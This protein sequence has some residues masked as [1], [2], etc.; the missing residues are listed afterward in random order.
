MLSKAADF[1]LVFGVT[2]SHETNGSK[3]IGSFA[4]SDREFDQAETDLLASSFSRMHDLTAALQPI[5]EEGMSAFQ[6]HGVF[7]SQNIK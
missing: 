2:W 6:K 4:R 5:N 7:A 1:G 3:S